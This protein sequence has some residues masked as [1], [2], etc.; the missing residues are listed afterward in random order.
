MT[1][2]SMATIP[3]RAD[4]WCE[5]VRSIEPQVDSLH[6]YFGNNELGDANKFRGVI[7]KKGYC[8]TIDDDLIYPENYVDYMISKIEEYDRKAVITLHGKII[9]NQPISSFY[10]GEFLK[11]RCLDKVSKDIPVHIPGTGVMAWH[12]DTIQFNMD[13][14][15][16]KN[17]ADIWA[18]IKCEKEGVQRVCV[19]HDAGWLQHISNDTDLYRQNRSRDSILTE[20]INSIEWSEL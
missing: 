14:F 19:K 9:L 6:Y 16:E 2:A 18:G 15:P 8:F 20:A 17:M 3:G 7:G 4:S 5:A 12:S 13:D 10:G 11:F 1:T